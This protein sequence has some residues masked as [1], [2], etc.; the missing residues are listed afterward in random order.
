MLVVNPPFAP[1]IMLRVA[2]LDERKACA[3]KK[4]NRVARR[5][6]E[7]AIINI[8]YGGK[9]GMSISTRHEFRFFFANTGMPKCGVAMC[10][11]QTNR[12]Q[13]DR[14]RAHP[15]FFCFGDA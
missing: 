1:A 12:E 11:K 10:C 8:V 14:E 13:T 7:P 9:G 4:R 2:D 6:G 5:L 15:I 3:K